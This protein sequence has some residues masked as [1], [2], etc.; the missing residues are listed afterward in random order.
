[1]SVR[2]NIAVASVLVT[3]LLVGCGA[4]TGLITPPPIDAAA[5]ALHDV[6]DVTDAT[7]IVDVP[8]LVDVPDV[9]DV[10]D[11][12]DSEVGC[13][14]A[15]DCPTGTHCKP[16]GCIAGACV[17]VPPPSDCATTLC[18]EFGPVASSSG[19]GATIVSDGTTDGLPGGLTWDGSQFLAGFSAKPP[20]SA[21]NRV[22]TRQVDWA[23]GPITP[24]TQL[25][26]LTSDAFIDW[27]I[28]DGVAHGLFFEDRSTGDWQVY[29]SRLNSLGE[30][31]TPDVEVSTPGA[32]SLGSSAGW[33][34]S[35]YAVVYQ[36]NRDLGTGDFD[37]WSASID[38]TGIAVHTPLGLIAS[39][40]QHPVVAVGPSSYAVAVVH[41]VGRDHF[42]QA[43]TFNTDWSPRSS[44]TTMTPGR[45]DGVTPT[46]VWSGSQYVI[47]WHD[48][49]GAA[50][51]VYVAAINE[52]GVIT[53]PAHTTVTSS[54]QS[55]YPSLLALHDGLTLLLWSDTRD[56]FGGYELYVTTLSP[57][58]A[59]MSE[60]RL[61]VAKGNSLFAIPAFAGSS[62]GK[63][64][65][66]DRAGV[67]FQDD[68]S[69]VLATWYLPL[70]CV[71]SSSP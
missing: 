48:Q 19:D 52:D 17:E 20:G 46:I 47:A 56:D 51:D 61:T 28:W 23:T 63:G 67:H 22:F 49:M 55:R 33:T 60:R 58:L 2:A 18:D 30:R 34:G 24:A 5:D 38:P 50:R 69:G 32:W 59:P 57:T 65:P 10:V 70:E 40:G 44:L 42:I 62:K 21:R 66:I 16:I 39:E 1:L 14:S 11:A 54:G 25:T 68:R 41:S 12:P 64:G 53:H 29:F 31:V 26:L 45:L 3:C 43:Q 6:A 71:R 27:M 15:A 13:L 7:D 9:E 4:K 37:V 36:D 8:D 35:G